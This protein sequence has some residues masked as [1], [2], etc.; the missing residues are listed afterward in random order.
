ME[1]DEY[2]RMRAAEERHWWYAGLHDL[3]V[4]WVRREAARVGK[5]LDIL[6]SGCGTGQL[7]TLL[8]AFGTITGCDN[9]PLALAAATQR[10]IVRVV[11]HDLVADNLG[12]ERYD[13]ITC[14]DVLYHRAITD[15]RA[16]L[17]NLHRA[18]RKGGLFLIQVPAFNLLRGAHDV[19]VHTRRRYRRR[20]LVRLL[21]ETGFQVKL[22]SYR[23]F[24]LFLPAMLWRRLTRADGGPPQSDLVRSFPPWMAQ[25]LIGYIK[26]ENR[27]LSVGVSLPLGTSVFAAARK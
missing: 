1:P 6:D 18:L 25:L 13:V 5:P 15:E 10:G 8:Q 12:T 27:C 24:P 23:L 2:R 26:A 4:R 21:R 16:A 20:E 14:M 9:H 19:A 17:G 22:A 7:C 3:V 11:R